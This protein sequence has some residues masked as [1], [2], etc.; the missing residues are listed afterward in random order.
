MELNN[1]FSLLNEG[2]WQD[3]DGFL[4]EEKSQNNPI[5]KQFG[6]VFAAFLVI[7]LMGIA[8]IGIEYY[9]VIIVFCF[10]I[11]L[12]YGFVSRVMKR[13]AISDNAYDIEVTPNKLKVIRNF[14][15]KMGLCYWNNYIDNKLL[16]PPIY[17]RIVKG[18]SESYILSQNGKYGIYSFE[19][20]KIIAK[21]AY[22]KIEVISETIYRLYR[23]GN[24]FKMN[25]NGDRILI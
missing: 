5:E 19:A 18:C 8:T 14:K 7:I 16:L 20:K 23:N 15:H 22:D 21:C 2:I 4:R 13:K 12:I 11:Y 17:D 1:F 25:T 3:Y 24:V 9:L 10:G 6:K